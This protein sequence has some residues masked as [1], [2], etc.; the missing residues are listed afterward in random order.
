MERT[1][2][3]GF[4]MQSQVNDIEEL[5]ELIT[6]KIQTITHFGISKTELDRLAKAISGRGGYR[7]VPIG[8]A[9]QF[10]NIWDGV[11]LFTHMTRR[12][13]VRMD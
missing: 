11:S 7:V 9:L 3:G 12:L 6:R 13:V 1:Q 4:I 10:E 2:G 5:R 8:Q